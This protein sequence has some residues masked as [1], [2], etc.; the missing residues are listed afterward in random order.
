MRTLAPPDL[1]LRPLLAEDWPAVRAIFV[2]GIRSG[3]ASF[4]TEAPTWEEWDAA[5][6]LRF[7]AHSGAT[8]VGWAAAGAVSSRWCYRGVVES[9]V[10]VAKDVRGRGVG[11]AVMEEL[12]AEAERGGIWTI[13]TSIFPENDASV[14]L[15]ERLGFRVV[16]VRKRI[17]KR[18][19]LWRDTLLM[20]RRSEVVG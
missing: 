12:I 1:G 20:E 5:H 18:D 19:G 10:Y 11:R 17:G 6:T 7:V 8:V 2:D 13:Q 15:H 16:G 9:S 4:E 14:V 3:L